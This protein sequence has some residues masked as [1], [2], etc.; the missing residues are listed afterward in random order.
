MRTF[1][2]ALAWKSLGMASASTSSGV[3]MS[4]C[5]DVS[6]DDVSSSFCSMEPEKDDLQVTH[7][8]RP[9]VCSFLDRI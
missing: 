2:R 1:T 7:E 9:W 8:L 5:T 6:A 3:T 4:V